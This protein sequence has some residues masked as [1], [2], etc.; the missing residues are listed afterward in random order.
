MKKLALALVLLCSMQALAHSV[1]LNWTPS[2][3]GATFYKVYRAT[4]GCSAAFS[5]MGEVPGTQLWFVNG[6]NPDGTP[7]VEGATYCYAVTSVLNGAESGDSA[8]ITATIPAPPTNL[9]EQT[10]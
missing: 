5:L 7:L 9:T 10:Q 8:T 1:T 2:T 3:T 6:S 4:G